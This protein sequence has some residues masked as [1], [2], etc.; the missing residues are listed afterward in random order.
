MNLIG[1]RVIP[2]LFFI[3]F[4]PALSAQQTGLFYAE[5]GLVSFRSEA[6]QEL[7]NA[8]SKNMIGIID[9]GNRT[10]VFRVVI[11]TFKGFNSALQQEH[12]NEKYLESEKYPEASF[13]GKII[14]DIDLSIDGDYEIRAKGKLSLHG[15]EKERIIRCRVKT[16]KGTIEVTS[17]FSILLSDFNI[18][19]PKVVHEKIASEILV[20]VNA[21]LSQKKN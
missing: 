3:L 11:R 1:S 20:E 19:V 12:F 13:S 10:F 7:I 4:T 2:V 8:A 15:V 18:K 9:P 16:Q 14:E 5:R 6:Q 21:A 17:N